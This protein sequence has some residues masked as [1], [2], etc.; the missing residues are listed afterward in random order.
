MNATGWKESKWTRGALQVALW[1]GLFAACRSEP[2]ASGEVTASASAS[3]AAAAAATPEAASSET[4][5]VPAGDVAA[6]TAASSLPPESFSSGESVTIESAVGLGCEARAKDHWLELLCRKRNG[7]GGRPVRAIR[8]LEAYQAAQQPASSA[9]SSATTEAP[10][11]AAPPVADAL[12]EAGT[13]AAGEL[14]NVVEADDQGE[15]RVAVP[16]RDG[17]SAKI[18]VQWTDTAYDLEVSGTRAKLMLPVHLALRKAC[19][20]LKQDSAAVV[21]AA[22][23]RQGAAALTAVD[24]AKLPSFGGCQMAGLGAWAL[25]L[26]ELRAA[27]AGADRALTSDLRVVHLDPEGHRTEASFGSLTFAPR[28]LRC[29]AP[30]VYDYD[31]DGQHE[32]IVRYELVRLPAG[33]EPASL[34]MVFTLKDG[35]VRPYERL[36]PMAPGG[37]SVEQLDFDMRPDVADWGPYL[38]FLQ[39]GCGASQC[40]AR[41]EG[42]RFFAYSL[43]DGGFSRTHKSALDALRRACPK[44]PSSVVALQGKS[45]NVRQTAKNLGCAKAWGA[46]A[47]TL[48]S[49]L[50]QHRA[51]LCGE[52]ADCPLLSVLRGWATRTPPAK[53]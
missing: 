8:D 23:K 5:I 33:T 14:P 52:L 9:G 2:A 44:S 47:A 39:E 49:Q 12:E 17:H 4:A 3:A 16:W 18:R 26:T 28:G 51:A 45:V 29:P 42:P 24:T 32:L 43:K 50:E 13:N 36:D 38:A 6:D 25:S 37:T 27:G 15:L 20:K 40:P 10:E 35:Q 41:I 31:D 7:T 1:S 19:A 48:T 11:R 53:L 34:P 22:Q 21:S 46:D 30:M